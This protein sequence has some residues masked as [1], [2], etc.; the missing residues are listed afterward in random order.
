MGLSWHR[1]DR[2]PGGVQICRW[3]YASVHS[4][5]TGPDRSTREVSCGP[6]VAGGLKVCSQGVFSKRSVSHLLWWWKMCLDGAE[7]ALLRKTVVCQGSSAV[8]APAA[9]ITYQMR[10]AKKF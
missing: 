10:T 6:T 4:V 2:A 8:F 9:G 7:C 1:N 3:D 5:L